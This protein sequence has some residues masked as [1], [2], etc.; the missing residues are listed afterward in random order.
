MNKLLGAIMKKR[1]PLAL[2][3]CIA[4]ILTAVSCSSKGNNPVASTTTYS[5]TAAADSCTQTTFTEVAEMLPT[6]ITDDRKPEDIGTTDEPITEMILTLSGDLKRLYN[7]FF[8][9]NSENLVFSID[10]TERINL[11]NENGAYVFFYPV[12]SEIIKTVDDLKNYIKQFCTSEFTERLFKE[13]GTAYA[14]YNDM[15]YISPDLSG[16]MGA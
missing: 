13:S 12:H 9:S 11:Y 4:L 3:V 1:I 8:H 14:D 2:T 7:D 16:Y 15:L 10:E 5:T 6:D